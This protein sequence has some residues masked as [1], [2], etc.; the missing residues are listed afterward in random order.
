MKEKKTLKE[1]IARHLPSVRSIYEDEDGWWITLW[2]SGEYILEG[3]Y[4][5]YTIHEDT[6][7]DALTALR[8]HIKRKDG[9]EI[10]YKATWKI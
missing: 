7:E 1:R 3:Y 8:E 10:T 6:K 4:S 2:P 9:K 5:E